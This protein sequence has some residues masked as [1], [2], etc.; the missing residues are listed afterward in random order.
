MYNILKA[1]EGA[2]SQDFSN[3]R[4]KTPGSLVIKLSHE[5]SLHLI[6]A[7]RV[8][9]SNS[10]NCERAYNQGIAIHILDH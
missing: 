5:P 8:C 10:E 2:K 7:V 4:T 3:E 9:T 1:E 6:P